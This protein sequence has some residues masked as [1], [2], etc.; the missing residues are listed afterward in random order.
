MLN[1]L[2]QHSNGLAQ[3]VYE[4]HFLKG[5][6]GIVDQVSWSAGKGPFVNVCF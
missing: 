5:P 4:I 2:F 3:E 6:H 1:L